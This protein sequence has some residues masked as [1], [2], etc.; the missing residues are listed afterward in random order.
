MQPTAAKA[1]RKWMKTAD[2]KG[3]SCI[4]SYYSI[5]ANAYCYL[6][7]REVAMR[8][9]SSLGSRSGRRQRSMSEPSIKPL[10]PSLML[11]P[12]APGGQQRAASRQL[13][14]RSADRS[15]RRK[16]WPAAMWH[17]L[18]VRD[19]PPQVYHRGALFGEA[20]GD[21]S[22][23]NIHPDWPDYYNASFN[24]DAVH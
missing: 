9:F 6:T 21:A 1:V 20:R 22:H 24:S 15:D 19:P 3:K 14:S 16:P 18:P 13:A 2:T 23:Y 10:P 4:C 11:K 5:L 7:E 17:H 8:L 12:K